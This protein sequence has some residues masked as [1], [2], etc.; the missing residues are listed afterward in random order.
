MWIVRLALR[1]PYTFV[2]MALLIAILGIVTITRIPIDIFPEVD[3][4]VVAVV[5]QYIGMS[6][7][8]METRVVG[9]FERVLMSTVSDIEHVESQSLYGIS[10]TK[11]FLQPGLTVQSATPQITAVVQSVLRQM[12]PGIFPALVVPYSAANVASVQVSLGSTSLYEQQ[13]FDLAAN[14]LRPAMATVRGAQVPWPFGGKMRQ[15]MVDL[16]PEKLYAWKISPADV[17]AAINA[18]NVIRWE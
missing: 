2:V 12:P 1:R 11:V 6:P 13:L 8:D 5:W 4:P 3:I 16:E 18:Q 15:V 10:V 17:S 14:V 7:S 9:T